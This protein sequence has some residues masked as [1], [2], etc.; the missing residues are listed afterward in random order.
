MEMAWEQGEDSPGRSTSS[1]P[2][3]IGWTFDVLW[4]LAGNIDEFAVFA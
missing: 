3:A 4:R 2:P 1:I